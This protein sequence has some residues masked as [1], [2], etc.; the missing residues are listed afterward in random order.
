MKLKDFLRTLFTGKSTGSS[1]QFNTVKSD[2]IKS[3]V[4]VNDTHLQE[5]QKRYEKDERIRKD[6]LKGIQELLEKGMCFIVSSSL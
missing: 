5:G 2:D 3:N 6:R 1:G 4:V